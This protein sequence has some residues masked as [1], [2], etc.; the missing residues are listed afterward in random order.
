VRGIEVSD[1]TLAM[2]VIA[3]VGP[4]GEFLSQRHTLENVQKEHYIPKLI[5]RDKWEVWAKSGSKDLREV[6][7][8][9]AKRILQEHQPEPLDHD[10]TIEIEKIAMEI[11]QKSP[12]ERGR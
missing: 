5:S 7:R 10:T 2:E 12:K 1:R 11:A 9:E 4:G 8:Q 6:A 3:A